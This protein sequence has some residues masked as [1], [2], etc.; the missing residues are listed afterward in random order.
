MMVHPWAKP[1]TLKMRS[2]KTFPEP[3]DAICG[4]VDANCT[5]H[6]LVK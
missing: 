2:P 1:M 5:D 6:N 4:R 3:K